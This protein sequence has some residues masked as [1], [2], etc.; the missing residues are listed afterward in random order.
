M[1][2]PL[3]TG[4]PVTVNVALGDRAYDIAIGR[5]LL[6]TLGERIAKLRPGCK[7]AIVTDMT[8]ARHH[9]AAAEASLS[10][11]GIAASSVKVPSG[12]SSKSFR[13]FEQVCDALLAAKIE[14]G[15]LVVALGGG[16]VGDLGGFC[17]AVVRRGVDYRAGAD[18]AAGPGRFFGRR[19]DRD[20][21]PSRQEPDRRVLSADPGRGRHCGARHAAGARV[22]RRLCR[23]GEVRAARRRRLL[24][25]ARRQLA[26]RVRRRAGARARHRA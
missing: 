5:G 6:D 15:D 8:V 1:T 23:G 11:A 17:S 20:Q 4:D 10:A 7:V 25:V 2:A 16:V 12:E 26:R 14:R 18:D 13:H 21:F 3:R 19:Q 24:R 9:L 22:P